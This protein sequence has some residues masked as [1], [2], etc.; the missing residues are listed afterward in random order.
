MVEVE[1]VEDDEDVSS[2]PSATPGRSSR[3]LGSPDA[4][5][6]DADGRA[7][8]VHR[9][10]R[11]ATAGVA[12]A[13]L[14]G[15]IVLAERGQGADTMI[16]GPLAEPFTEAW[17]TPADEVQAVVGDVVVVRSV[18]STTPALR[19][20]D[21]ATGETL[22]SVPLNVRGPADTCA[23]GV[24]LDPP[25]A[26]CWRERHWVEGPPGR[27][28]LSQEA[29]VGIDV[30]NGQVVTELEMTAPSA[31]QVAVGDDLVMGMRT[32]SLLTV[33][34]VE[35]HSWRVSWSTNVPLLPRTGGGLYRANL[36]V[37][38]D[39]VVVRG[40]TTAV[41]DVEDGRLLA[42]W[43]PPTELVNASF[44]GADVAVAEGG[45]AAW[46]LEVDGQRDAKGT[47]Y[48]ADGRPVVEIEGRLAE[49]AVSDG[50]VPRV[51]LVTPDGGRTLAGVDTTSGATL[52]TTP[53]EE[54]EVVAR[55]DGAVLLTQGRA[56][57]SIE[58]LTGLERWAREVD[59]LRASLTA[60]SDGHTVV[61]TSL[62]DHEWTL[63]AFRVTDGEPLWFTRVPGTREVSIVTMP[64]ELAVVADRPVVWV[65]RTLVWLD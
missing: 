38:G 60:L 65:G 19:G 20:L 63:D 16:I 41:L 27:Y 11:W 28:T 23:A 57:R 43:D 13:V 50:S 54:G 15:A 49:P 36:D 12:V 52:W 26:W 1:L 18:A 25:T 55:H 2:A 64:P 14:T 29:L 40:P 46:S 61:V 42:R 7:P 9:A 39:V 44:D 53:L 31:G 33:M 32:E 58:V 8:H 21:A 4:T 30:A 24:T 10:V 51:L 45:F 47:W 35:P 17:A 56:L 3:A 59:G 37:R 5:A 34:R 48:D 22:W 6:D 62:R